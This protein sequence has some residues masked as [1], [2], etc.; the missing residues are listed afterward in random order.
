MFLN[1]NILFRDNNIMLFSITDDSAKINE[2]FSVYECIASL[3]LI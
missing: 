2:T 1:V 3:S